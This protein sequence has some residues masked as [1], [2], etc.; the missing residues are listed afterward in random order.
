MSHKSGHVVINR[1]T[2]SDSNDVVQS[3]SVHLQFPPGT[4]LEEKLKKI[5]K[6]ELILDRLDHDDE[7]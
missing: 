6:V 3:A 2:G 5:R 7:D 1:A 4:S